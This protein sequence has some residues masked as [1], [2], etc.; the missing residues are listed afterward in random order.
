MDVMNDIAGK[1][2]FSSDGTDIGRVKDTRG[3]YF[4]VDV[5]MKPDYWLS[6]RYILVNRDVVV[7][8]LRN[9]EIDAHK[10]DAPGLEL[11]GETG[12]DGVISAEQALSQRE[13]MERELAMQNSRLPR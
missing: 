13:R 11:D 6:T 7:L 10:L 4:S 2:I 3:G 8:S 12:G 9:A 1:A 5:S